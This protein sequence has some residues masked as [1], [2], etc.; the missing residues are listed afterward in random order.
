LKKNNNMLKLGLIGWGYWGRNYA[1]Y[2]DTKLDAELSMVCD[3]RE[4]ML[5]DAKRLYPHI[6]ITKDIN[7]L[8]KHKLDGVI[9]ASPASIHYKLANV[10]LNAGIPLLIEKPL[11]NSYKTSKELADLAAKKKTKV[12][13]G[14]TFLY[15]QSVQYLKNEI[16]SGSF[17]KLY[18][19][20]FRRQSYGPIRDDV[21]IVWD[22]APHDIAITKYL[23][24]N[25]M[26][27]S[28]FAKAGK[29]SRNKME[30]MA[31]I[32]M[33][34]PNNVLVNINVAWLY[35]VKI[36]S[37]TLL[38][39]KKMAVF[40]DTNPNEPVKIYDTSLQYPKENDPSG[41]SFRLGDIRV[42]RIK[43][44]DPL[45]TELRHF[46]DYIKDVEKP[47]TPISD[48]VDVVAIIEAINESIRTGTEISFE[49]WLQN[50]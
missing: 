7:D 46:V 12:L 40:E 36:R 29:F 32:V 37:L 39:D 20:E 42:P 10:F 8:I 45:A 38:G 28:V 11:T 18:Y 26:P 22:F 33:K 25:Q 34:Y 23:L 9:L 24:G 13:V 15:N 44:I 6:E 49:Q 14:H 35:P 47:L 16:E 27:V 3:L 5:Q 19:L 2:F 4:D 30:D 17:G 31:V 50:H 43:A 48:G 41:A 1:K 21:N